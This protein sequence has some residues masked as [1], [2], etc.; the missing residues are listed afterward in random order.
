MCVYIYIYVCVCVCVC[1]CVYVCKYIHVYV[2]CAVRR[3][4]SAAC[5]SS[6][7]TARLWRAPKIYIHT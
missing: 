2:G 3:L 5:P 1:V 6:A 7:R 4:T